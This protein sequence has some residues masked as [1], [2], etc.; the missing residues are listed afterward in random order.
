MS[1]ADDRKRKSESSRRYRREVVR[2]KPGRRA[3]EVDGV[4]VST[5]TDVPQT[6]SRECKLCGRLSRRRLPDGT[7]SDVCSKC[8]GGAARPGLRKGQVWRLCIRCDRQLQKSPKTPGPFLCARCRDAL[9]APP[10]P[11]PLSPMVPEGM[12]AERAARIAA[13]GELYAAVAAAGG[14]QAA[15]AAGVPTT[16]EQFNPLLP[17]RESDGTPHGDG[18]LEAE[19][20]D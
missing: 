16:L 3:A 8:D 10:R 17:Q 15:R 6:V 11:E 14:E 1:A 18:E 12:E 4:L 20:E 13:L 7:V 19:E 2:S 9:H 5:V